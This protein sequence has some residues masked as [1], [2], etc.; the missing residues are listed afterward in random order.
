MKTIIGAALGTFAFAFLLGGS[1]SA[2]TAMGKQYAAHYEVEKPK[3][4]VCHVDKKTLNEYGEALQK[5]LN[6]EKVLT[7]AMFKACEAKRPK[8]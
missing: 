2:T 8:S 5:A 3:C 6:G 1:A 4:T 7:P